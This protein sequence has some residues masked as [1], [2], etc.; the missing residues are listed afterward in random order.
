MIINA[1]EIMHAEVVDQ[2]HVIRSLQDVTLSTQLQICEKT[3]L[4]L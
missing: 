1:D 4:S 3:M 2:I